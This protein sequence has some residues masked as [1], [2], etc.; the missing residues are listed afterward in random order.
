LA[1]LNRARTLEKATPGSLSAMKR[2][3]LVLA[4]AMCWGGRA[5]WA[6][7]AIPAPEGLPH[8]KG[9]KQLD[10][11]LRGEG[12][13]AAHVQLCK[14]SLES[15]C[16]W[17]HAWS[18]LMLDTCISV[19]KTCITLTASSIKSRV[20]LLTQL[21]IQPPSTRSSTFLSTCS[22]QNNPAQACHSPTHSTTSQ[23]LAFHERTATTSR[24]QRALSCHPH[25]Q[26]PT[27]SLGHATTIMHAVVHEDAITHQI[28][29][30][31]IEP[32]CASLGP[33]PPPHPHP[34]PPPPP[35]PPPPRVLPHATHPHTR[36]RPTQR[37][38]QSMDLRVL[39]HPEQARGWTPK[40]QLPPP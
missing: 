30:R 39:E 5:A 26:L 23:R 11:C 35:H 24:P 13:H 14:W 36:Q 9:F 38:L 17:L 40:G 21:R 18:T 4:V 29:S 32:T 6:Q 28:T 15:V 34:P 25:M 16:M 37:L 22:K 31:S 27:N 19:G 10:C 2:W 33:P 7:S 12:V 8:P 1:H 3:M 20:H